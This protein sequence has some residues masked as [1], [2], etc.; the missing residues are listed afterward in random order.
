M[1]IPKRKQKGFTIVE[2]LIVIVVIG[3]LATIT[4]VVYNGIQTRAE[5]T[6]TVQAVSQYVRGIL[7]YSALNGVYPID[8]FPC[9]GPYPGTT[10]GKVSGPSNCL[11]SGFASSSSTFDTAMRQV[12]SGTPPLPSK[13]TMA[14]STSQMSGAYY[15]AASP[16]KV[17]IIVYFIRGDQPCDGISGLQS[18]SKTQQDDTTRCQATFLTL[19]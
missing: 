19:P 18:L 15:D 13:Q 8:S 2:L 3:I 14:C 17:A 5:N 16:G 11:N 9:L 10:C 6:K 1:F 12:F 7:S 4:I